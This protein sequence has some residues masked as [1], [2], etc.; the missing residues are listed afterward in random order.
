MHNNINSF[1]YY[2]KQNQQLRC[3][4]KWSLTSLSDIQQQLSSIAWPTEGQIEI[5]GK[6]I[7]QLD[8]AGAW[9]LTIGIKKLFSVPLSIHYQHF[10]KQQQKLISLIENKIT[11]LDSLPSLSPLNQ[12]ALIGQL[13][14]RKWQEVQAFLAFTGKLTQETLRLLPYPF[15]WRWKALGCM[16]D[17]TGLRA[18]PIIALLSFMIGVVI[19]Y[20]MGLQLRNYGANIFIV[21]LLGLSI[22]R[23]FG[24]LLAAIM[25]AG[26]TG[27]AFTAQLGTM[28]VNQEIDALETLGRPPTELLILPR[29]VALTVTLPL[30]TVWSDLFGVLG[31]M[32]MAKNLLDISWQDFLIRFQHQIPVKALLIGLGKAPIFALLIATIGC[33]TGMQ[34]ERNA[35]SVGR[36]T[37]RSVVLAI[38]FIIM[39][40]AAFSILFSTFKI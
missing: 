24:P 10:S 25:V 7:T 19:T 33:F 21:D 4:G 11:T 15:R 36:Q 9:L 38:F 12:L 26:R 22:L 27:S 8:S 31:G 32:L 14:V 18:L 28:K 40:D 23:E 2:N 17:Q 20:Q 34:V 13:V 37:T 35:E 30:L 3:E 5:D 39:A 6:A 29:I 16:I 1:V